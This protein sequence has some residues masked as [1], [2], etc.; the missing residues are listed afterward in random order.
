MN[1]EKSN[2]YQVISSESWEIGR[3][4]VICET[5]KKDKE[6][7]PYSYVKIKDCVGVLCIV[8][9]K[10]LLLRQYRHSLR[11]WELEIPA[12]SIEE[13]EEP[14]LAAE[15]EVLEETGFKVR[16]MISLGWYHLSSGS[17]T[18]KV[19]LFYA[20]CYGYT[21]QKLDALEKIQL[22]LVPIKDFEAM[23]ESN[24]FHQCLGVTAWMRY[25]ITAD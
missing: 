11:S 3:F 20:E 25:K 24:E 21:K 2:E 22:Q 5:V 18:E 7:Y 15:R 12:G 4:H 9:G 23:I 13:G 19:Y 1:I 17:T 8:D 6:E 16:E 14:A 10:I